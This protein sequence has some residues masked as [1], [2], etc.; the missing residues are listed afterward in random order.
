MTAMMMPVVMTIVADCERRPPRRSP[1]GLGGCLVGRKTAHFSSGL[2]GLE[3]S[4]RKRIVEAPA[5]SAT[6]CTQ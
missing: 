6:D 3:A 4:T 5:A 1:L 2:F